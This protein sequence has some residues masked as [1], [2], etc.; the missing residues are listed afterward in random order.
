[1]GDAWPKRPWMRGRTETILEA[2]RRLRAEMT[3]AENVLWDALRREGIPGMRFRRQHAIGR[4]VLDFY[5]PGYRLAV[6]VDGG[7]HDDPDQA[8]YDT[9]RTEALSQLGIRVVRVRNEEVMGNLPGVIEQIKFATIP[10][11]YRKAGDLH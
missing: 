6:E 4:F 2:S 7:V 8:E 1:M 10:E 9:A 3:P 11:E 5:C